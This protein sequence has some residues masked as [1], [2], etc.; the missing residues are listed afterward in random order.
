MQTRLHES[1][2]SWLTHAGGR[3]G[4]TWLHHVWTFVFSAFIA[5]AFTIFA[6]A[7]GRADDDAQGPMTWWQVY[8]AYLVVSLCIGYAIQWLFDAA[9]WLLGI[10]RIRRFAAWQRIVFF[11]GMPIVGV[12]IGWPLGLTL[13]GVRL[14]TLLKGHP[15]V[16]LNTLLVSLVISFIFFQFF[17]AKGRQMQAERRATEAQLKLLQGQIEPHF[18][19]NTLANVVGLLEA[20]TPRA[21]LMLESFIDYLRSSLG[22]LRQADHTLGDELELVDA[23]LRVIA[24]RMDDRLRYRIDVPDDLRALRLPALIV[25]P[26]VENAVLHGLEPQVEGGEVKIVARTE[27]GRLIVTVE[28]DG[29]GLQPAPAAARPGPHAGTACHNIRERL[30]QLHGSDAGLEIDNLQPH[31]VRARLV[32]PLAS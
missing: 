13:L 25:Q 6:I 28:D 15:N 5:A 18:L 23:Y 10:E 9:R 31:G 19:F 29:L 7:F 17:A 32:L 4:P 14:D 30:Q 3:T 26:L 2:H 8:R 22:S 21:K 11:G 27:K 1:W 20:D 24:I 12:A 16:L